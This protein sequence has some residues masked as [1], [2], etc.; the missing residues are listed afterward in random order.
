MF[1]VKPFVPGNHNKSQEYWIDV[2]TSMDNTKLMKYFRMYSL[3][4]DVQFKEIDSSLISVIG[5]NTK[6]DFGIQEGHYI[7]SF[8]DQLPKSEVDEYPGEEFTE[9]LLV[10][11]PRH[12]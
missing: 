11:D 10:Q 12:S 8:H 2:H 3:R 4:K 9:T 7:K 1:I 5:M 6:A